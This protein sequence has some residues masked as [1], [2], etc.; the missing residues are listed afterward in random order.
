MKTLEHKTQRPV[1]ESGKLLILQS[2]GR[3]SGNLYTSL[4]G[5]IQQSNQIEQ[6]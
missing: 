3:L 6:G 4:R 2:E 1:T 5:G